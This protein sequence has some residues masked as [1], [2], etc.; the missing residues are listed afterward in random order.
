MDPILF[1]AV[2]P[3]LS[4]I[5]GTDFKTFSECVGG[6]KYSR[7]LYTKMLKSGISGCRGFWWS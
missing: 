4:I 7:K 2:A 6:K 1:I 3:V 5:S